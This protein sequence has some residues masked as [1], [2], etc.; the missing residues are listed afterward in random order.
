MVF[1]DKCTAANIPKLE[2][3]MLGWL[4]VIEGK[5]HNEKF[6]W[7]KKVDQYGFDIHASYSLRDVL[8]FSTGECGTFFF[9]GHTDFLHV[10]SLVRSILA[11]IQSVDNNVS[12]FQSFF[13][14]LNKF[15]KL[16]DG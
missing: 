1:F 8:D 6:L 14:Y 4:F 13:P 5:I 7:H 12:P 3:Q 2:G 9:Q 16:M 11:V 10:K 15:F